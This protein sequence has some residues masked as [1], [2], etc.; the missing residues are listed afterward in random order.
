MVAGRLLPLVERAARLSLV[1]RGVES[2]TLETRVGRVHIYDARGAGSLPSTVIMHGL[3]SAATPFGRVLL[4]LRPHVR[5]VLA[6][7][8][9]GHGFSAVPVVALSIELLFSTLAD[10]LEQLT[11]TPLVL[12]GNSLGGALSLRY[13]LEHPQ[14]LRALVLV[15][16]AG[17]EMTAAEREALLDSFRMHTTEDAL[18]LLSRLYH[19][20]PF[21]MPAFAAGLRDS[22]RREHMIDIL[23]SITPLDLVSAEQLGELTVPTLLLWGRSERLLPASSLAYFRRHLP[24]HVVIEEPEGFGHCPHVDAPARLAR[25][26]VDFIASTQLTA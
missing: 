20:T 11:D 1:A 19:R 22:L 4:G 24:G 7:D 17:A 13:A 16:P 14:R 8:L 3:G 9:P 25:R 5:R 10:L 15:S 2:R 21:Y 23:Q 12:I 26:I 18:R 6:P